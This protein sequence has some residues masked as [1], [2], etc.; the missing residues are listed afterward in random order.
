MLYPDDVQA[1]E[2]CV[3]LGIESVT[4][5]SEAET[6]LCE[7]DALEHHPRPILS[8]LIKGKK[9][10]ATSSLKQSDLSQS[11]LAGVMRIAVIAR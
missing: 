9:Q 7:T 11:R 3:T 4:T 5:R 8:I 10:Q 1:L 6:V 2:I